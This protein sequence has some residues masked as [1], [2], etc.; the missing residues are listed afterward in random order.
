MAQFV[1]IPKDEDLNT[2]E[3]LWRDEHDPEHKLNL[4]QVQFRTKQHAKFMLQAEERKERELALKEKAHD[5][6]M[7]KQEAKEDAVLRRDEFKQNELLRDRIERIQHELHEERTKNSQK[8]TSVSVEEFMASARDLSEKA[9][10]DDL[11]QVLQARMIMASQ[12]MELRPQ[13][14]IASVKMLRELTREENPVEVQDPYE[15]TILDDEELCEVFIETLLVHFRHWESQ[16]QPEVRLHWIPT[17]IRELILTIVLNREC[18]ELL[19]DVSMCV[20]V[21]VA[22]RSGKQDTEI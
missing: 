6:V 2:Q 14:Y 22:A 9:T 13:D 7:K 1:R 8:P 18:P 5:L 11:M 20:N 16:Q 10:V 12:H 17:F 3:V 15:L 19:K 21:S 4:N